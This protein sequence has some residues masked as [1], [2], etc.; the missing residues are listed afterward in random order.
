MKT[1]GR[2]VIILAAFA[3]VMGITYAAVSSVSS[4]TSGPA[5]ARGGGGLSGPQGAQPQFPNGGRPEG[6]RGEGREF[7][8]RGI[9]SLG[10]GFVKNT[11]IIAVIVAGVVWLKNFLDEKRRTA[12]A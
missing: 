9:L 10:L 8:G 12:T 3:L 6:P 2:I 11:V 4:S 1:I 7:G 5:F